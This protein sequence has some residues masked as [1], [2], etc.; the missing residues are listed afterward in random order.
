MRNGINKK[1]VGVVLMVV[2]VLVL[3]MI[4]SG[5]EEIRN[6]P[7]GG[8]DIIAFGDSLVEGYGASSI[9]KNFVSVLSQKIGKPIVNL[10][11]SGNTT[12]DGLKRIGELDEYN[13]KVVLL[14]LGGNDFL[15]KVPTETTFENLSK[16]IEAIQSRG[17][18]VVL[19][20]VR[21]GIFGGKFDEK[22]EELQEKYETVY[23]PDVLSGLLGD[24][25]YMHDAIHPNDVGYAK[26]AD[27]LYPIISST[28][29]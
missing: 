24:M 8:T 9:E 6:F 19:L 18:V 17:A 2:V 10:G 20:G 3:H 26:I 16:I 27:R 5:K 12:A 13:P 1:V 23:V 4:F 11:V 28:L 29:K 15:R 7:S 22:F 14:L 25:R 21:S